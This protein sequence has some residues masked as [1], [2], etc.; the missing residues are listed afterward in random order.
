MA[1]P[2]TQVGLRYPN[3]ERRTV[4]VHDTPESRVQLSGVISRGAAFYFDSPESS[5][6]A[7]A[8]STTARILKTAD[9]LMPHR[10][11]IGSETCMSISASVNKTASE[12]PLPSR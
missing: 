11:W 10:L 8:A 12:K 6:A 9:A 2:T 4:P 1:N 7:R 3:L 5:A